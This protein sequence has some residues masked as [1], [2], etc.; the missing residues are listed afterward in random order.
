MSARIGF[1]VVLA[2]GVWGGASCSGPQ[3]RDDKT[4]GKKT[5]AGDG[6][7]D[8][9]AKPADP[10]AGRSDL[11]EAPRYKSPSALKVPA[12]E[13]FSLKN[14]L[15]VLVVPDEQVPLISVRLQLRVGGI[16]DPLD[17]IGLADFTAQ[18]L[19]QGVRGMSA[20]QISR[21]IDRA[22]AR[23]GVGAGYEVSSVS[24]RAQA[25]DLD[26]CL[27]MLS[28]LM[29]QPTF[30]KKEMGEVRDN[31][32]GEVKQQRDEPGELAS[33]HFFNMLYGDDHPGGL[34]MSSASIQSITRRDLVQFHRRY[35]VP[36]SAVLAISGAVASEKLQAKV[37]R[38]FR[39]WRSRSR[40]ERK[41]EPVSDPPAG[42]RV[43]LVDKPDLSQSFFSLG[44]AGIGYRNPKHDAARVANYVL[45]GGGFSS[46]LMQR[47]RSQGGKTY[48]IS[49]AF[50]AHEKDGVFRVRSFTRNAQIVATLDL[51]REELERIRKQP[52][53]ADEIRAAKGNLAGGYAIR[54]KTGGQLAAALARAQLRGLK[55][56]YVTE[57]AVRIDRLDQK[58]V[59]QATRLIHPGHLVGAI[60]GK[61]SV[62]EPL[63]KRA[64]VSYEKVSYL[65][66]IS[67]KARIEARTGGN[68]T[69]RQARA[70]KRILAKAIRAAGGA[71][72][73][74][75]IKRVRLEGELKV[76]M[77]KPHYVALLEPP[78]KVR[79][80]TCLKVA[81][82]TMHMVQ[83]LAG[84]KAYAIARGR[85][86]KLPAAMLKGALWRQP[87]FVLINALG[88]DVK[89]RPSKDPQ[90]KTRKSVVGVDLFAPNKRP[91]TL[92]F[93]RK[94]YRL[95]GMRYQGRDGGGREMTLGKHKR[96]KGVWVPYRLETKA[97]K[98]KQTV[99]LDSVSLDPKFGDKD[100]TAPPS[101][102][103]A[104]GGKPAGAKA[105]AKP[106]KKTRSGSKASK[107][108]SESKGK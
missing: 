87:L 49:S 22:G 89:A 33:L 85:R 68:I 100:I 74:R 55:D 95:V 80:D 41:L 65:E 35:F 16:D 94:T 107:V 18:M 47:V 103:K 5:K 93:D 46:R 45:G 57:F 59:A 7:R 86:R 21:K 23:L 58:Q 28:R 38:A 20:D 97:G 67:A 11:I 50:F 13:R 99:M 96:V 8:K 25:K 42:L 101:G 44:H 81:N 104:G 40:P 72:R 1:A 77:M 14:G 66:P 79:V 39:R 88:D 4:V 12:L 71:R 26:L 91:V 52:P 53:T 48:G 32:L 10:W 24:C 54:F 106:R 6:Q 2:V 105:G 37:R 34:P 92:L 108:S 31:L 51:V 83:V 84:D 69:K 75:K 15:S 27:D 36:G 43:L 9:A 78:D 70:A 62:V 60:V 73:L 63:L 56:S 76:P 64:G 30:P 3:V 98:R 102:C 29:L 90:V 17:K 61:A 19:R 82:Q